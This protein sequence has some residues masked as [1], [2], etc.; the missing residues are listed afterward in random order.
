MKS[1]PIKTYCAV[2]GEVI[3]RGSMVPC[4]EITNAIN[5][6]RLVFVCDGCWRGIAA[7]LGVELDQVVARFID[8][9]WRLTGKGAT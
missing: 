9:Q 7:E 1:Y 4:V 5:E 3:P 6:P 8:G 2:G